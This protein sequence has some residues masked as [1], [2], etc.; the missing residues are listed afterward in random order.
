MITKV[1]DVYLHSDVTV[2]DET[3]DTLR[4]EITYAS[5][6]SPQ[7]CAVLVIDALD[8]DEEGVFMDINGVRELRDAF[9]ELLKAMELADK[10]IPA[11][12]RR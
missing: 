9:D 4:L 12:R 3:G 7:H 11:R 6:V 1:K 2:T 10:P 5:D 8:V